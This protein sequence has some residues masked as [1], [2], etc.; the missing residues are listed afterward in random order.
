MFEILWIKTV[1]SAALPIFGELYISARVLRKAEVIPGN[2]IAWGLCHQKGWD[3]GGV[4][5]ESECLS[6]ENHL[7][8]TA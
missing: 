8:S 6:K 5:G 7:Q 1:C 4:G 2:E 3:K